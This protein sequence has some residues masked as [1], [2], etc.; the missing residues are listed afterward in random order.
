M[1]HEKKPRVSSMRLDEPVDIANIVD[2][3]GM[4]SSDELR[5]RHD[6][7]EEERRVAAALMQR[8]LD[9]AQTSD[10]AFAHFI[11]PAAQFSGDLVC[12]A[13]TPDGV[14]HALLGDGAGHGLAAALNVLPVAPCFYTMTAKGLGIDRIAAELNRAIRHYLP[15]DRFVAAI[16]VAVDPTRC[17]IQV[18]N[19]GAPPGLILDHAGDVVARTV[20][21]HA[22]LG[23][24]EP[25]AFDASLQR[26][27]F[28]GDCQFLACSDGAIEGRDASGAPLGQAWLEEIV[29]GVPRSVRMKLL[30]AHLAARHFESRPGDDVTVMLVSCE[31][32]RAPAQEAG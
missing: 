24:V 9:P 23:I 6:A 15:V 2:P 3:E 22:P 25:A 8:L 4:L 18:W 31:D 28:G 11:L 14:L 17:R 12:A 30:R 16:L 27:D 26:H 7:A 19:G 10:P 5:R 20:S 32:K 21:R 1:M 29:R 13:R